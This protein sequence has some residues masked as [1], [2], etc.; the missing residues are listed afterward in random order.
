MLQRATAGAALAEGDVLIDAP[1]EEEPPDAGLLD[2]GLLGLAVVEIDGDGELEAL[3]DDALLLL[4][5]PASARPR[6]T[7]TKR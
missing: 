4:V 2:A 1:E 3:G 5:Q 7:T 6:P